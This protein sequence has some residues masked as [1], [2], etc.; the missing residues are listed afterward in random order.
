MEH[1]AD[2]L[3]YVDFVFPSCGFEDEAEVG[4]HAAV[5]KELEVLE[6]DAEFLAQFGQ[7]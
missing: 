3:V 7:A 4:V 2:A 5:G 1:I 6:D